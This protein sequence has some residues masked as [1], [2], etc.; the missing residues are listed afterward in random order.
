MSAIVVICRLLV[1]LAMPDTRPVSG[2]LL[3]LALAAPAPPPAEVPCLWDSIT[4]RPVVP[5]GY[6]HCTTRPSSPAPAP[7]R[8]GSTGETMPARE[9]AGERRARERREADIAE[10]EQTYG[11]ALREWQSGNTTKA[12]SR[13]ADAVEA[14]GRLPTIS[15][16]NVVRHRRYTAQ[17]HRLRAMQAARGDDHVAARQWAIRARAAHPEDVLRHDEFDAWLEEDEA[18]ARRIAGLKALPEHLARGEWETAIPIA[19]SLVQR[20][21]D[22]QIHHEWLS[23]SLV[24]AGRWDDATGALVAQWRRW[25]SDPEPIRNLATV[26]AHFRDLDVAE[27]LLSEAAMIEPG[28]DPTI[29]SLRAVRA[30]DPA[31][32]E[33]DR[34]ED[35]RA[36]ET[37]RARQAWRDEVRRRLLEIDVR[38]APPLAPHDLHPGDVLV[39]APDGP[40]VRLMAIADQVATGAIFRGDQGPLVSHAVTFLGRDPR[41]HALFLDNTP[42]T[43]SRVISE[44]EF[45]QVYGARTTFVARPQAPVDGTELFRYAQVRIRANM[46]A[47]RLDNDYGVF[48]DDVVCSEAAGFA[49]A[50]ATRSDLGGLASGRLGP[51][52]ITPGDFVDQRWGGKVFVVLRMKP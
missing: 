15:P 45:E 32:R 13:M 27:S 4:G 50:R 30:A 16:A 10:A 3:I 5:Q 29:R 24:G 14:A 39:L 34:E 41:G 36:V 49:V 6:T 9:T 22:I 37:E 1:G 20:Y 25:P 23:R 46:A 52:D 51:I 42:L 2:A 17:W 7:V 26:A 35:V 47:G 33:R 31:R 48:G 21:P 38:N 18:A 28:H 12:I 44:T 43:G 8:A 11:E 40:V 19:R